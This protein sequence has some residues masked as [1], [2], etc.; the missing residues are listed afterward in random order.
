MPIRRSNFVTT[1]E[2]LTDTLALKAVVTTLNGALLAVD[3]AGSAARGVARTTAALG[4]SAGDDLRLL[5]SGGRGS[6][7]LGSS[8]GGAGRALLTVV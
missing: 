7:G 3:V 8:S 1:C 4:G 6:L 5:R 2:K